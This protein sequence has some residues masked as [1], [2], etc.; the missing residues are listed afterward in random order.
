MNIVTFDFDLF[1]FDRDSFDNLFDRK[2]AA[3]VYHVHKL[4]FFNIIKTVFKLHSAKVSEAY[5]YKL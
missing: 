4:L 5:K 2:G 3:T 1:C